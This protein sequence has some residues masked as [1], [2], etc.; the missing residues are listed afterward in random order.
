MVPKI[1]TSPTKV[2]LGSPFWGTNLVLK[3]GP[4]N[5]K[6]SNPKCKKKIKEITPRRTPRGPP[7]KPKPR[8]TVAK[9]LHFSATTN[10]KPACASR[11]DLP[12]G[13]Y[14]QRTVLELDIETSRL[15]FSGGL[16]P[17]GAVARLS[18]ASK[19][20][21]YFWCRFW[22]PRPVP[23]TALHFVVYRNRVPFWCLKRVPIFWRP[24]L[25][26]EGRSHLFTQPRSHRLVQARCSR[27]HRRASDTY[28][29][30]FRGGR[31]V[32]DE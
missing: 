11:P 3:T 9:T 5:W 21:S 20:L 7:A 16:A 1:G 28:S 26:M 32:R 25:K 17:T 4:Q 13:L 27:Y 15:R 29:R 6:K 8:Q 19:T 24:I 22:V 10:I 31:C 18:Q 30:S 12:F 2:V 23:N 14:G